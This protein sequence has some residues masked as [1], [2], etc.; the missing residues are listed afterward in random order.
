MTKQI[1]DMKKE[2]LKKKEEQLK[3]KYC[4]RCVNSDEKLECIAKREFSF[5]SFECENGEQ[6]EECKQ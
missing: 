1:E 6:F 5:D 4:I 2:F 3:N